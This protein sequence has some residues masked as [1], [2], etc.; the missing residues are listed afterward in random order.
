M[1]AI[2]VTQA[3]PDYTNGKLSRPGISPQFLR[4]HCI[5]HVDEVQAEAMIGFKASGV[6]IPYPGITSAEMIVNDRPFGRLRLDRP[7]N[8][9]KYLS[10]RGS[11]AHLFIPRGPPFGRELVVIEGEFKA[12]ALCEAGIRAVGIGGVQS[13]MTDGKLIPELDRILRKCNPT[14]VYFLGDSDTSLNFDFSREAVKLAKALP[15]GCELRLPRIPLSMPKGIDDCREKLGE[16]FM[17]FW[18]EITGKAI[19]VTAKLSPE[20]LAVLIVKRELQASAALPDKD[21]QLPRIA[22]LASFLDPVNLEML[23][24]AV[25]ETLGQSI[26]GFREAT[27]QIAA[28]RKKKTAEKLRQEDARNNE[29]VTR[30]VN[31]P[32]PKLELP[33]S[34]NRLLSE[35]GADVGPILAK[36]GFFSKDGIVVFPDAQSST[37]ITITGRAFRTKIE[38]Y[39]IP[40]R[41]VKSQSGL[42][43]SFSRTLQKEDAESLLECDQ[44]IDPLPVIRAVN[45]A[46]F[47]AQRA[48]GN[49]ELLPKGYDPTSMIFTNPGGPEVE[50]VG[51][52]EAAKFLRALLSEFCFKEQDSK[53]AISVAVSAMLSL[54]VSQIIPRAAMRPGFLYTANAE[55]SGKTLLARL[56]I[57]PRLGFTPTG[58]LPEQEEEVQKLVFSTAIAGSPVLFFDNIRRHVAS[59]AIEGAMTAPFITGRIL[60][61]SQTLVVENMMTLFFTGNEAT[62]SPD[63]RRRVLHVELFLKEA[64]SEDRKINNPLDE[65]AIEKLRPAI[66][67]ALWSMVHTWDKAG[68]PLPKLKLAGYEP[69][70]DVVC[71]ILEHAGFASPCTPAPSSI[72]GDRDTEEMKNLVELLALRKTQIRFPDIVELCQE[73][74]L[75]TRLV[76]EGDEELDPGTKNIFS[77]ILSRVDGRLFTGVGIFHASRPTKHV[78]LFYVEHTS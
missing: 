36:R 17:D 75:F 8:G 31:D 47:P 18:R 7:T 57:A 28:D 54:F 44:L 22:E 71:G 2:E 49:I 39:V 13:A 6:W 10:P 27:K 70:S 42:A 37:L 78:A 14:S 25:K 67:S 15:E 26:T 45:N 58:A 24:K 61:R 62:I 19:E 65:A 51:V 29:D 12:M 21:T 69:W 66:L 9:A 53:R 32:R 34:R 43:T 20:A 63:L 33:G 74:S 77:R 35:F 59:G 30:I 50:D 52:G 56:A 48:S 76:G 38:S 72:S 73:H 5:R 68:R 11:G 40:F 23:A 1:S 55:G 64:R 60:G 4:R 16:R 46:R 3:F 41:V